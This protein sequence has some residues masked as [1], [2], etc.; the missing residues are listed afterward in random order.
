[1]A[2]GVKFT[3]RITPA[4]PLLGTE[5]DA[6]PELFNFRFPEFA[7]GCGP[8]NCSPLT[9]MPNMRCQIARAISI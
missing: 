8:G 6:K 1:L 7:V 9:N 3:V 4:L 5:L 2:H